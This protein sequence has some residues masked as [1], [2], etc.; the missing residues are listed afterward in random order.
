M[1]QKLNGLVLHWTGVYIINTTLHGHLEIQNFSSNVEKTLHS[2]PALT[3][4]IFV[5]TQRE[6]LCLCMAMKY[7]LFNFEE[8]LTPPRILLN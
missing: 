7:P 2:F 1:L 4:E 5:S 3:C 8:V 6:I